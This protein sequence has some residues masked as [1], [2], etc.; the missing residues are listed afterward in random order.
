MIA[1]GALNLGS[2]LFK[3]FTGAH[4]KK[5]GEDEYKALVHPTYETPKSAEEMDN[6]S[7]MRFFN[8]DL[9]GQRQLEEQIGANTANTISNARDFGS[10]AD[11]YKTQVNQ[12]A[13]INDLGVKGA[14]QRLAN[15]SQRMQDLQTMADYEDKKFDY[16]INIPFQ[17]NRQKALSDIAAGATNESNGFDQLANMGSSMM[18]MGGKTDGGSGGGG[19]GKTVGTG[20]MSGGVG[21]MI[22]PKSLQGVKL[23]VPSSSV[24]LSGL[25]KKM[26]PMANPFMESLVGGNG[27]YLQSKFPYFFNQ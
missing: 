12:N 13:A 26:L 22:T 14:Q 24:D 21:G 16:N 8:P 15:E 9:A 7:A 25:S 1:G 27:S 19:V 6:I 18:G 3:L 2:S 17:E 11:I 4:Q 23:P 5:E 20:L 10:S